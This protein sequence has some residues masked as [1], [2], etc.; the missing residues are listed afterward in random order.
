M[1]RQARAAFTLIEVLVVVAIIALLVAILLPSLSRARAQARMVQCQTNVRT[2][3][4]AFIL[5][6]NDNGGRFPGNREDEYADWLGG[7]NGDPAT[8]IYGKSGTRGKQPEWGTIYKKYMAKQ[9]FAYTCPEDRTYRERMAKGEAYHSFTAN[10]LLSGAKPEMAIGAHYPDRVNPPPQSADY[11]RNN[12]RLKMLP[13]DGAPLIIEEDE[14]V[15]LEDS[16]NDDSGWA[17]EDSITNR[18]LKIG[19]NG[20]GSL[21]FTDGHVGRIQAPEVNNSNKALTSEYLKAKDFC[22]RLR[23]KWVSG[24]D[25]AFRNG[26]MY[27]ALDSMPSNPDLIH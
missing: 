25:W 19:L 5:Y 2:L 10:L 15:Y 3:V 14:E 11:T 13:L 16:Y 6:A 8:R 20:Y 17:N 26:G 12:H 1:K 4:N 27:K 7:D 23:H 21:G 18:H 9:K 24:R 22:L